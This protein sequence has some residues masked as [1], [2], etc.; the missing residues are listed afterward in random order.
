MARRPGTQPVSELEKRPDDA[1]G[2]S[3]PHATTVHVVK[4]IVREDA[5]LRFWIGDTMPERHRRFLQ[6]LYGFP[7]FWPYWVYFDLDA[8]PLY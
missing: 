8:P 1:N 4:L 5:E 3:E 7:G 6:P 2:Q